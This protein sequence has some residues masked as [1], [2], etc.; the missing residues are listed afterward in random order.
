MNG[1]D[2][3]SKLYDG[4]KALS[5]SAFPK[6]CPTCGRSYASAGD[7]VRDTRSIRVGVSGLKSTCDEHERSIV[8]LFRN[9]P[10]GSTLMDYFDDRRATNRQGARRRSTFGKM[11]RLLQEN[12]LA[13]EEARAELLKVLRGERSGRLARMGIKFRKW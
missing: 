11:L 8:E 6:K 3:L 12:G 1:T 4:L 9:C 10:C 7:F 13:A 5:E 2:D